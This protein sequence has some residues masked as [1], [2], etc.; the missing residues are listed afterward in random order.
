VA[1]AD[2]HLSLR[3][4]RQEEAQTPLPIAARSQSRLTSAATGMKEVVLLLELT[5]H[6]PRSVTTQV[7]LDGQ[8]QTRELEPEK[9]T[10]LEFPI[11]QPD[12]EFIRPLALRIAAGEFSHEQEWMLKGLRERI[13]VAAVP[14]KFTSGQCLRGQGETGLDGA[15]GALAHPATM[16]CGGVSRRGLFMHPPYMTGI[17]YAFALY[18]P[19]HL[20]REPHAAFRCNIGKRDGSDRG[21]GILLRVAVVTEDGQESTV[22]E[23]HWADYAWTPLEADLS[24][25]AGQTVRLKLIA[26]VGRANDSTGDWACWADMKFESLRPELTLSLET[27]VERHRR[28]PAPYP[29]AGLTEADLRAA[30][31]GWLHYDGKGLEGPGKWATFA[32]LNGLELGE[33]AH[34]GGGEERGQFAE[35]TGV[36]LTP[37]ALRSLGLRNR[38]VVKNPNHDSF[39]LRR[40]WIEL[41]LADGRRCS[42]EISAATFS[43]PPGWPHAEGI[44][45]P[46]GEDI[47]VEI[48]LQLRR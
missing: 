1:L 8:T 9:T 32:V 37:E 3:S 23:K 30:K 35:K 29:I 4:S 6:V 19:V 40:F 39:S 48:W 20:P 5:P 33:M 26:D 7:T 43:Q 24:R 13:D 18:D 12:R 34:A 21:D 46:F 47:A 2:T 27:D 38:F 28:T 45:V 42:S 44:T 41:E 14:A 36:R 11:A 22:A 10:P 16:D 25:W 31:S 17:G 15:S